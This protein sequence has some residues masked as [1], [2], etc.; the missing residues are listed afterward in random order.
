MFNDFTIFL[1]LVVILAALIQDDLLFTVVYLFAGAFLLGRWWSRRA[2]RSVQFQRSMTSHA[3]MGEEVPVRLQI[4]NTGLLPVVW[5]TVQDQLPVELV[6]SRTQN[7]TNVVLSLGPREKT[8]LDYTLL[9]RKRGYYQVGPL[10]ASSGDLLGLGGEQRL[11]SPPD[12]LTVYPKI[13]QFANFSLPS[14]ISRSISS[15]WWITSSSAPYCR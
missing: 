5:M 7:Q 14:F 15:V 12:V 11:E 6:R 8:A 10:I 1:I 13:I 4:H 3:F 9:T 2:L